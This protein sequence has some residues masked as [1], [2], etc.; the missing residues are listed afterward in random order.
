MQQIT[1]WLAKLGISDYAQRVAENRVDSVLPDLTDQ[2][3]ERLAVVLGDRRKILRAIA[4]FEAWKSAAIATAIYMKVLRA[5]L[6][7]PLMLIAIAG[8]AVAGA[9]EDAY[10][11]LNEGD[12]AAALQLIRPLASEGNVAARKAI[13]IINDYCLDADKGNALAQFSLGFIYEKGLGMPQD[14]VRTDM[15]FSLAAAQGTKGAAEWRER[16]AARM[17]PTQITEAQKLAREWKPKQ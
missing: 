17:S 2:D 6:I 13:A 4:N 16:L 12:Y 8:T 5:T 11:A 3:L 1:D 9:L 14:Y 15:W 7:P 10:S